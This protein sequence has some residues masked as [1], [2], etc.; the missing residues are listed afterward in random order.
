MSL[1]TNIEEVENQEFCWSSYQQEVIA[2]YKKDYGSLEKAV[3]VIDAEIQSMQ[4]TIT[5]LRELVNW[6]SE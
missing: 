3:V 2:K 6:E 1:F 4:A 5:A